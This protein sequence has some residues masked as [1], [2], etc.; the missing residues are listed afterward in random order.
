MLQ[1]GSRFLNMDNVTE[2]RF[3]TKSVID[4]SKPSPTNDL[5][6][7][8]RPKMQVKHAEVTF[9]HG[10]NVEFNDDEALAALQAYCEAN[11]TK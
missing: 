11:K 6:D 9:V 4:Y 8:D 10:S 2:I 1:V 7:S 3:F 5:Y